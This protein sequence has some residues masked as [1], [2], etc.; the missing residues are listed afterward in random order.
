MKDLGTTTH[1]DAIDQQFSV[2]GRFLVDVGAGDM[3]L[4]R[5]LA[6]RGASVL[7]IEPDPVQAEKNRR[8]EVISNVGFAETTA[9]SIPVEPASV[10]GVVFKY[11]L[12]HIPAEAYAAV[13]E[14][15]RRILKPDGFLYVTEP[16]ADGPYDQVMRLFHNEKAVRADAQAALDKYATP[17]FAES[18]IVCYQTE[19][20]FGSWQ[21]FADFYA[22]LSYNAGY[23]EAEVRDERVRQ[24]FEHY[25]KPLDYCFSTPVVARRF[26]HPVSV[27][28]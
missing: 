22:G 8:A 6:A 20:S 1:I 12:H 5:L 27:P 26:Q 19:R 4:S 17:A 2:D 24:A 18:D 7:A 23:T 21:E 11:S 3:S 14:E 25:G 16:V 10:D 9:E 28:A 13:F 15:V